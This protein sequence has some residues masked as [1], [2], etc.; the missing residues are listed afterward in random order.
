MFIRREHPGSLRRFVLFGP[1]NFQE[2][3]FFDLGLANFCTLKP[4]RAQSQAFYFCGPER[5]S[6]GVVRTLYF[7]RL[8][9]GVI[10]LEAI[11]NFPSSP[12]GLGGY[13][14]WVILQGVG[15]PG[16]CCKS[17]FTPPLGKS[18]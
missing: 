10:T 6:I 4:T 15:V 16:L 18:T 9:W 2:F 11:A 12:Y 3:S 13:W 14:V 5:L 1:G 7:C 17:M 8:A